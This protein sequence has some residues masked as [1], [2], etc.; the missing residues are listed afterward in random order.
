MSPA[1]QTDPELD[2]LIEEITVDTYD[3]HEQLTGF[4]N[5]F[6]ED[7]NSHAPAPLSASRSTCSQSSELTTGTN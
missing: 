7:A 5:A 1:S 2:D 6:D 4:E 3:E